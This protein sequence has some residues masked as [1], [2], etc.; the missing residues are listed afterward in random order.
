MSEGL[1]PGERKTKNSVLKTHAFVLMIKQKT[2]GEV[3]S[4]EEGES[5]NL[6]KGEKLR[7][8]LNQHAGEI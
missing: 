7:T 5:E 8:L 6:I 4:L 2:G 1:Q 3:A